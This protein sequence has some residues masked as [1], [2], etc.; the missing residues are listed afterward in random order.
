M[1][2]HKPSSTQIIGLRLLWKEAFGDTDNFLDCFF[3]F[4]F[5]VNRCRC[6]T[7]DNDVVAMLYWFDCQLESKTIAYI[8]AVATKKDYQKKGLCRALLEH[9]HSQLKSL[10]YAGAILVPGSDKLFQFYK[11]MGYE[12]CS[13]IC[14]FEAT[15][16]S[17]NIMVRH[18]DKKEYG[19]LRRKMLPFNSVIQEKENLDFLECQADFIAG[20]DF[21]LAFSKESS[22]DSLHVIEFLGNSK[23]ASSILYKLGFSKGTF[24]GPGKGIPFA[25][26]HNLTKENLIPNYFGLAFD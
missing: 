20:N 19:M 6:V 11:K 14:E 22:K 3:N 1:K 10:G 13:E 8:Y 21:L 12:T 5:H 18:V 24:R 9:T 23:L 25:M 4:A 26:Y 15:A 7:I 2:I 16:N 17:A